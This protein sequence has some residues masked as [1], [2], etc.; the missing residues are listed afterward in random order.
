VL[1]PFVIQMLF[2]PV[3]VLEI[4]LLFPKDNLSSRSCF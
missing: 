4:M 3:S 2:I 1:N